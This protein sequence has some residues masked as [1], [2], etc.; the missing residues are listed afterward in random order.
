MEFENL[1]Q[2]MENN[3][4]LDNDTKIFIKKQ[5]SALL[6]KARATAKNNKCLICGKPVDGFC[7]SH[8]VPKFCL[9]N[10]E[11]QGTVFYCNTLMGCPVLKEDNG[12]GEAGVFFS[13]CDNCDNTIFQDYENPNNLLQTPTSK[14]LA[15]IALKNY[16]KLLYKNRTE[17]EIYNLLVK[18]NPIVFK[19][20]FPNNII[21]INNLDFHNYHSGF[22]KA[23]RLS[24]KSE[25]DGYYLVDFKLLDYR[26]P[27]AFQGAITLVSDFQ[28][29]VVN[30]VY[31]FRS[32]YKP[33]ELHIAVLPL[34]KN[35][36]IIMF[37]DNGVKKFKNF[38]KQF[39]GLSP[40]NQLWA[41]NYLIFLY[42]E[43]FFLS[44]ELADIEGLDLLKRLSGKTPLVLHNNDENILRGASDEFDLSKWKNSPNLLSKEYALS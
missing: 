15:E 20:I 18:D 16:L 7:K 27:I 17:K 36:A 38:I 35:T 42:S 37:I 32:N 31:N 29:Q 1:Q 6:K 23:R 24:R 9:K 26:V 4:A 44:K 25:N 28:G 22:E 19:L 43:D 33:S 12:I 40:S 10:I 14:I 34:E 41:I 3:T 8:C 2:N 30:D 13:I 5:I 21:D 11:T 39:K